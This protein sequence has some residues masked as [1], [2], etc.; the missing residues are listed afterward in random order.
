MIR[1]NCH[2]ENRYYHTSR[3]KR[4]KRERI[5][6]PTKLLNCNGEEIKTGD[7]IKLKNSSYVGIVL[8]SPYNE[9]YGLHFGLWYR[10]RDPFNSDCYGKFIRIPDDNGM[11]MELIPHTMNIIELM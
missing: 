1:N 4:D 8:W 9:C 5:G 2:K 11:K 7:C 3:M 6:V 10:G